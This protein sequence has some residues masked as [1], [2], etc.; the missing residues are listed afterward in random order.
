MGEL[1][2]AL[3][4]MDPGVLIKIDPLISFLPIGSW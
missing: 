3:S 2:S 4:R 1:T